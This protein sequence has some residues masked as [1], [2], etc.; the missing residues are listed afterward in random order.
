MSGY[1][2]ILSP[3]VSYF[4]VLL[5]GTQFTHS[6][7]QRRRALPLRPHA[8]GLAVTLS[9]CVLGGTRLRYGSGPS[10]PPAVRRS[11]LAPQLAGSL[12]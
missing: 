5:H 10:R 9:L 6:T 11:V 3:Q 7:F 8:D 4:A 2:G 1:D 12:S